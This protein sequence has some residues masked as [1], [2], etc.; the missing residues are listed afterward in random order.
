MAYAWYSDT[1][2]HLKVLENMLNP[3]SGYLSWYLGVI[4]LRFDAF[5]GDRFLH[6]YTVKLTCTVTECS[7]A[8]KI[9]HIVTKFSPNVDTCIIILVDA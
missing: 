8:V 4:L 9:T 6:S 7:Y 5:Q 2:K 1:S 3:G